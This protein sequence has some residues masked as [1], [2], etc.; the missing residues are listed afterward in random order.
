MLP[1]GHRALKTAESPPE[2]RAYL[3]LNITTVSAP[4]GNSRVSLVARIVRIPR[5]LNHL[6][7]EAV[8]DPNRERDLSLPAPVVTIAGH[9]DAGIERDP[10]FPGVPRVGSVRRPHV[11]QSLHTTTR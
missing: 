1:S 10:H 11:S 6:P 9:I 7:G 5:D 3:R 8:F 4:I 2:A